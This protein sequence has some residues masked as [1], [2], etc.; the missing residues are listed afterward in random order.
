MDKHEIRQDPIR[1]RIIGSLSYLENNRNALFSVLAVVVIIIAGS[2]YY[3][4]SS[5]A[6]GI[7]SASDL[8]TALIT[9]TNDKDSGVL[10]LSKVLD[11]GNDASK[12]VAMA[13][14]VNH[15]YTNDQLFEVDSLLNMDIKITDDVIASKLLSLKGDMRA[16]D[17][18]FDLALESYSSSLDAYPS[19]E[20]ELKMANAHFMAGDSDKARAIVDAVLDNDKATVT[21][22]TKSSM[23]KSKL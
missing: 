2:G 9:L 17:G 8:G 23:L 19:I 7:E 14:L 16:N 15:Y 5:K 10:L 13:T 18:D 22:K 3:S 11:E 6:L 12:Q 1:E 20:V 4:S 21:L